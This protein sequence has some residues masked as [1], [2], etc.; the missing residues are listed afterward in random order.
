MNDVMNVLILHYHLH[1]G[2]VTKIIEAQIKGLQILNPVPDMLALCGHP[3][4]HLSLNGVQV[5]A[6][7]V[8]DYSDPE[9]LPDYYTE[10]TNA[11]MALIRSAIRDEY[12]IIHC[13]NPNLGKNPALSAAVYKLAVEGMPVVFHYHDFAEDRPK[14]ISLMKSLIPILTGASLK[15]VLYPDLPG[16]HFVVLNSCDYQRILKEDVPAARIHLLPNP[17]AAGC[18]TKRN[19]PASLK[20]SLFGKLGFT[21]NKKL[22]IYPVRAIE[23]KNLGE[24]ILLAALFADKAH[25]AVTQPPRNPAELTLYNRWKS[26]SQANGISVKF[27]AGELVHYEDLMLVS[28]FCITTSIREGFGMAYLEPWLAGTPVIGR[29]LDCII[30]DLKRKGIVFPRLYKC[31]CPGTLHGKPDFKDLEYY[32]QENLIRGILM[33]TEKRDELFKANVF[34]HT[35]LDDF[36]EEIISANKQI[37]IQQFSIEAYGKNLFEIYQEISG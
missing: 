28:D 9:G 36:P 21:D 18:R 14:N 31:I 29:E 12:S 32:E 24:F 20:K 15:E 30:S 19:Q 2:G 25:F 23:R 5:V 8:L 37:I 33:H 3:A 6:D 27:E 26:F 34:L 35:M 22:C 1:P 13:H 10:R 4:D 17:V 7:P 16:V 11:I